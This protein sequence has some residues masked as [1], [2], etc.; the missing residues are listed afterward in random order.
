MDRID[1]LAALIASFMRGDGASGT[2]IPGLYLSRW[3]GTHAPRSDFDRPVLCVMA[4]GAK[5][6][7]LDSGRASYGRGSYLLVSLDLPL[8]TE[9]VEAT[10]ASPCLGITLELDLAEIAT[11]TLEAAVPAPVGARV[12]RGVG[13]EPLD[14]GLLDAV[15]RL[16]ELLRNPAQVP[17]LAP[18][19]RRE[20]HYRL[21]IGPQ[22]ALL[23]R[24]ATQN[25]P[26]QR[27]AAGLAWLRQN[28]TRTVRMTELAREMHMSP[29]TM[30]AWFRA[31]TSMSPL[32][33]QK[34]LRLQEA[35]RILLA[36]G[37]GAAAASRRVGY[38]S[39]A[40]FSRDYRRFFGAPPM[41]DVADLRRVTVASG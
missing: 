31:A 6:V 5:D 18:L 28:A 27:V 4:Q 3:S 32:Q 22:G 1:R 16:A 15:L 8:V 38:E 19:I 29:S 35:R 20:I 2:S 37:V 14:D 33:Y 10:P 26:A 21:L 34:Q 40:Q 17:I 41:R 13:V 30:H 23:R 9:V 12:P 25:S 7:H 11:L 39:P 36:E 24:M